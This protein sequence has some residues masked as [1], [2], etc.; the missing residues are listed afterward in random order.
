MFTTYKRWNKDGDDARLLKE[1]I[2]TSFDKNN[3]NKWSILQASH[4]NLQMEIEYGDR[5]FYEQFDAVGESHMNRM[6][7]TF[8]TTSILL[9]MLR[10]ILN[11]LSIP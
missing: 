7:M 1:K 10:V 4:P 2:I 8:V 11:D 5:P 3:K 9:G 6:K